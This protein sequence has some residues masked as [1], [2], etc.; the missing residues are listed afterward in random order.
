[1]AKFDSKD[2]WIAAGG[3]LAFLLGWR[4]LSGV[5]WGI[6]GIYE[7]S[8]GHKVAGSLGMAGGA[9]FVLFPDWPGSL[10]DFA[11]AKLSSSGSSSSA[12]K[13]LPAPQELQIQP[14]QRTSY[15]TLDRDLDGDWRMLDVRDIRDKSVKERANGLK[16]GDV[17]SLVL[18]NKNGPY[19]V[20]NARVISGGNGIMYAGQWASGPPKSGP[21]M[22]EFGP[23]HIFTIH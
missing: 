12:P 18:Q 8:K 10:A 16:P 17:A 5:I 6:G 19:M 3:A 23:E 22:A 14:F 21:Q 2:F 1:M 11:R 20:F 9:S 13:Q 15:P 7:Y 4:R